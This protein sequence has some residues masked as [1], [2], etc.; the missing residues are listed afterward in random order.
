[1]T[2]ILIFFNT[3]MTLKDKLEF[4]Q[5]PTVR[6]KILNYINIKKVTQIF[7]WSHPN[8]GTNFNAR[9]C[10]LNYKVNFQ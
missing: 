4:E 6:P 1:M 9:N 3:K 7:I 10:K 2:T 5:Y 8:G